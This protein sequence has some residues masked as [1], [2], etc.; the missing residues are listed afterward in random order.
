MEKCDPGEANTEEKGTHRGQWWSGEGETLGGRKRSFMPYLPGAQHSYLH[1]PPL[2]I[3]PHSSTS[4]VWCEI[5][6]KII[7]FSYSWNN[8]CQFSLFS[9]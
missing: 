3:L 7:V 8:V 9:P 1:Q 2:G 5:S 6:S 4:T